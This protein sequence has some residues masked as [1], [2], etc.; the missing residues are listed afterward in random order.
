MTKEQKEMTAFSDSKG[1]DHAEENKPAKP[2]LLMNTLCN[3][4]S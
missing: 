1:Q 4:V 3:F 2:I